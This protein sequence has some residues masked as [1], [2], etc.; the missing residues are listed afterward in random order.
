MAGKEMLI[1]SV[2]Q[3]V[4]TY[5]MGC[6]KLTNGVCSK[7]TSISSGFWWGSKD[8]RRKTSWIVWDKMCRVKQEGSM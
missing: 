5:T 3:S 7:L 8:G 4:S 6:L 1:K 2:L